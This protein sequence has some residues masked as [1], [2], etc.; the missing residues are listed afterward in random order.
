M[1]DL[2]LKPAEREE[3]TRQQQALFLRLQN[4]LRPKE[5]LF[6]G[7]Y[8]RK[9][10]IRPLHDIDLFLVL[11]TE[12]V[13]PRSNP[14]EL[15]QRVS[16]ELQAEY[17]EKQPRLQNRSVNILFSSGIG[18]DVVPALEAPSHQGI[19]WIPDR[20]K[21]GWI[22]SN[23]WRHGEICDT[24][25]KRTGQRFNPLVKT[26]KRWNQVQGRHLSSFLMEVMAYEAPIPPHIDYAAGLALLFQFMSE[27]IQRE[28]PDPAKRGPAVDAGLDAGSRMQAQQRLSGAARKAAYA[29]ARE[30]AG[31]MAAAH[32]VWRELL[33][34]DYGG[35]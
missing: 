23:P 4:R 24:A 19:Y 34:P 2:E 22:C 31:D 26:V 13:P 32:S 11:P 5:A 25:N 10:A 16:R 29:V 8:G 28:N 1:K 14:A 27:R 18:F 6:S 33:G 17:R 7:S 15:L 9:T 35:R 20:N 30:R 21:N 3:A 12:E